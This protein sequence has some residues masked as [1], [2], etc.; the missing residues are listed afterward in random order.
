M[1]FHV[2]QSNTTRANPHI[3]YLPRARGANDSL[4]LSCSDW[5]WLCGLAW[6][7]LTV[8]G[9]V[10][11]VKVCLSSV[12]G[13]V[14]ANGDVNQVA[15]IGFERS[16]LPRESADTSIRHICTRCLKRNSLWRITRGCRVSMGN[17]GSRIGSTELRQRTVEA[18]ETNIFD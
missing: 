11:I 6:L 12:A 15:E 10:I 2:F 16:S 4:A 17:F 1:V 14:R 18:T 3:F 9:G 7:S 5:R 13:K 8:V